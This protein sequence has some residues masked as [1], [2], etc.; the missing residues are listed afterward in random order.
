MAKS[1]RVLFFTNSELGQATVCLAVA[2]EFL[3]RPQYDV[4]IASFTALEE[5]VSALNTRAAELSGGSASTATFHTIAGKSMKE[6]AGRK[7]EF[8]EMHPP[9]FEGALY[10]YERVLPAT[11]ASWNGPEYMIGYSSC[12]DTLGGVQ[13]DIV[14]IDPL[15]SQ[16]IDAC[17]EL[18]TKYLLRSPQLR[19]LTEYRNA[20]G[21]TGTT[22]TMFQGFGK[23]IQHL[24]PSTLSTDFPFTI[25]PNITPCG[26]ILLPFPPLSKTHPDLEAWLSKGPTVL[27]NLGSHVLFDESLALEFANALRVLLDRRPD[28]QVLWKLKTQPGQAR[29]GFTGKNGAFGVIAEEMA[30]GRVRVEEWLPAEPIA[31]LKSRHVGW[32]VHHGGSNSYHEAI[33][34]G[35]VQVVLPVW[36][37]T[38]D[39]ATRVEWLGIGVRGNRSAAPRAEAS[40]LGQA[41]LS[42]V[43]GPDSESMRVKAKNIA[44]SVGKVDGRVVAYEKIA[45]TLKSVKC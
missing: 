10:A 40:E 37:D 36:M 18:G 32:M 7:T 29:A 23:D 43:D 3:L 12:V 44:E 33:A 16:A 14:V 42:A 24:L 19:A 45:E 27:I 5:S 11:F 38:Y 1:K 9:G 28:V 21:V 15:L 35:V 22:P 17:N 20:C 31:I 41:L 4:H 39:F 34:A 2:H 26:P 13:P 25:P 30:L 6:A 8:V